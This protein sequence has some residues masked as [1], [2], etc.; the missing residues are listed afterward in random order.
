M[1]HYIQIIEYAQYP[2]AIAIFLSNEM[3]KEQSSKI[4]IFCVNLMLSTVL[5]L[6]CKALIEISWDWLPE[7]ILLKIGFLLSLVI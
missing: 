1:K 4:I 7:T 5:M 3:V 2:T 6:L